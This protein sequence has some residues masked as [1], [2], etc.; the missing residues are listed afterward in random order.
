MEQRS[1]SLLACLSVI[2]YLQL[3]C[4]VD[5]PRFDTDARW[6]TDPDAGQ[7]E[8]P[9]LPIPLAPLPEGVEPPWPEGEIQH[10]GLYEV[11]YLIDGD[12][13]VLRGTNGT[14]R[15][16]LAGID[17]PA[18]ALAPDPRGR[19]TCDPEHPDLGGDG[20]HW[21]VEAW[22][23]ARRRISGAEVRVACEHDRGVCERGLH[24]RPIV[25][26][27]VDGRDL[28]LEL[29]SSG[30]AFAYTAYPSD[31]LVDYCR[32]EDRA[33]QRGLGMWGQPAA[34]QRY[35]SFKTRNWY[36]DRDAICRLAL[37]P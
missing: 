23:L 7:P 21:G 1:K 12:T 28:S 29:A 25:W 30:A 15:V 10:G 34:V 11:A 35:L 31:N 4:Q 5:V 22:Q 8:P 13:A 2:V 36:R 24:G 17:A 6:G 9:R 20:E 27:V 14:P 16:R 3:C 26:I 32:A 19:F 33:R 37:Q 18:C